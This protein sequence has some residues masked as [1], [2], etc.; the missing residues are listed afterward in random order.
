MERLTESKFGKF[1]GSQISNLS[2][3]AGGGDTGSGER[4]MP[5]GSCMAYTS[6]YAHEDGSG[7]NYMGV[8]YNN[9]P[10]EK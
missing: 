7:T 3:I 9:K 4:C 10:C 8:S 6:D 2:A 1:E 5:D